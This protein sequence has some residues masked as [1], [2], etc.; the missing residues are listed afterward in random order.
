MRF[1]T[2][3]LLA[4]ASLFSLAPSAVASGYYGGYHGYSS[5][6]GYG[7]S[8]YAYTPSYGYG[9]QSYQYSPYYFAGS[10]YYGYGYYGGSY[11]WPAGYYAYSPPVVKVAQ[12]VPYLTPSYVYTTYQPSAATPAAPPN[13][14]APVQAQ[15]RAADPHDCTAQTKALQVQIDELKRLVVK[16]AAAPAPQLPQPQGPP[17]GAQAAP[18]P[19]TQAASAPVAK[20]D[21][22]AVFADRCLK[23]HGADRAKAVGGNIALGDLTT[24]QLLGCMKQV[25]KGAMPKDKP[26]TEAEGGALLAYFDG[27]KGNDKQPAAKPEAAPQPK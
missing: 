15:A 20:L 5:S 22:G 8:Y 17:A 23:C 14:V 4:F 12:Y 18:A 21:G 13:A 6:Y 26:L 1:V 27:L 7:S 9:S 25:I 3:L 11:P 24:V 10:T 2:V 16:S 19:Q